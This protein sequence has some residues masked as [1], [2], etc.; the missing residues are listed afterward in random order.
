MD[1]ENKKIDADLVGKY[2]AG[3]A[4]PEEAIQLESWL[5]D[6][7]NQKEFEKYV[8]LWKLMPGAVTATI[9]P[10]N[11]VWSHLQATMNET[12][13]PLLARKVFNRLAI[14]AS[15]AALVVVVSYYF[16]VKQQSDKAVNSLAVVGS[17]HEAANEKRIDTLKD[18]SVVIINKH[19]SVAY[20]S[21]FNQQNRELAMTGEAFFNVAHDKSK[22]F[23][24]TFPELKIEVVG[25]AFNVR[26]LP[27][28]DII[29][30]QVQSGIVK[31]Y[32]EKQSLMVKKGQ[33]GNYTKKDG[34]LRLKDSI[35]VNSIG[36]ATNSFYFNDIS[37]IEA[38]D[39]L[40]RAFNV[41][42]EIDKTKFSDCRL[43]AQFD[44]KSL[45]YILEVINATFNTT[46]QQEGTNITING[47]GCK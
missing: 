13:R 4:S 32:T 40:G 46:Y 23:I 10:S 38:C 12:R 47:N 33:T 7:E 42:I 31:M 37:L 5:A 26:S 24:I 20:T 1:A 15:V 34:M 19:S 8:K 22:P 45:S 30:V 2:L 28:T 41:D 6:P 25:T 18:G 35:D 11:E 39:Y 16:F 27:A 36:Y 21:A 14:A 3:E 29:E 9:P 17:S 44:N 43:T